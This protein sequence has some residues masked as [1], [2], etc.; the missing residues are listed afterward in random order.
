[1]CGNYLISFFLFKDKQLWMNRIKV[2]YLKYCNKC[3]KEV[4]VYG[5]S[6]APG[7]EGELEQL[8]KNAEAEGKIILF[9]PPPFG[10]YSYPDCGTELIQK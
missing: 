5:V 2:K 8:R 1:M 7:I 9:N 6:H 10:Q 4:V 3:K